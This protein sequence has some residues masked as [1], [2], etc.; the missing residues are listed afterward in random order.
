MK[1][2]FKESTQPGLVAM[3]I[4]PALQRRTKE[5][6]DFEASPSYTARPCYGQGERVGR[7]GTGEREG[8]RRRNNCKL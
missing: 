3:P 4:I 5:D 7:K 2:A 8:R 1:N 6:P